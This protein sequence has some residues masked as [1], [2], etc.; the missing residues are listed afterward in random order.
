MDAAG[1]VIEPD[2]TPEQAAKREF[3]EETG[4]EIGKLELFRRY[5][6]SG[7]VRFS[8]Y[9]YLAT[10]LKQIKPQALDAGEQIT[11]R[12]TSF[13]EAVQLSLSDSLRQSG[14]MLALL[15]LKYDTASQER[16]RS[17]L[18]Y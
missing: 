10:N 9:I 13:D 8:T 15:A 11:L 7:G 14:V 18:A 4:Y 2:E 6:L 12:P 1:G 5:D 3:L 16:L 17:F